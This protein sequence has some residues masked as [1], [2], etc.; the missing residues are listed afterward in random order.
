M[1]QFKQWCPDVEFDLKP[2]MFTAC[3]PGRDD[4]FH[5]MSLCSLIYTPERGAAEQ[6]MAR[7]LF[8]TDR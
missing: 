3:V 2:N 1:I 4:A 6:T 8:G 5:A 7:L